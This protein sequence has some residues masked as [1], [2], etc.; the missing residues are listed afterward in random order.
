M[1]ESL[2]QRLPEKL[3]YWNSSDS[4]DI[5]N[6][7]VKQFKSLSVIVIVSLAIYANSIKN[8]F[9]YDD[10]VTIV[11]NT[12]I[13]D[14]HNLPKLFQKEYFELSGEMSY[15]PVVTLT[16]FLDYSLY[17]E[18]P[19]GYHL[20]NIL[21]HALNGT[22]LYVF[23]SLLAKRSAEP[24]I[25]YKQRNLPLIASL[26]FV[27]HPV[28]TEAVNAVSF[29]EDL[30][31]FF[32][33]MITLSLYIILSNCTLSRGRIIVYAFSCLTYFL[34]LFSKEMGATLPLVIFGV[35][36]IY[37]NN[38]ER[39]FIP[40]S[41][42][43]IGY[44]IVTLIYVYLRFYYF[45]NPDEKFRP[46]EVNERILTFPWLF[47]CYLK[48]AFFPFSLVVDY[49]ITPIKS[50]FSPRF[51][52]SSFALISL[53][54]TAFKIKKRE[55]EI[56]FGIVFFMVTLSPVYNLI[57]ISNPFAERYLYLPLLGFIVIAVL[58]I[59]VL[60]KMRCHDRFY[61]MPML[62]FVILSIY[63]ISVVRRN[64]VW[65]DSYSLWSDALKKVPENGRIRN[66]LGSGYSKVGEFEK[67]IENFK[68]SIKLMA[69]N[70]YESKQPYYNLGS[71]Y[72]KLGRLLE[73]IP[74]LEK[75]VE[76]NP[77]NSRWHNE[78]GFT[79]YKAGM[80]NGAIRHFQAALKINPDYF[81]AYNNLGIAYADN[82]MLEEAMQEFRYASRLKPSEPE[83]WNNIG[84]IYFKQARFDEAIQQYQA[85]LKID[86]GYVIAHYNLGNAYLAKGFTD[87]ARAEFEIALK[88][89]P[90]FLQA[91]EAIGSMGK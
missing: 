85:S 79:Y 77:N 22:L 45:Q 63:S 73:A 80:L 35:E 26:L 40:V 33:F 30:L 70:E 18:S 64:E 78:T 42:Y 56:A 29:R 82:G 91:Q 1:V 72:V 54:M 36:W 75:A 50:F 24:E 27:T 76:L 5:L 58:L 23:L 31:V 19:W 71:A 41:R 8:G 81:D 55:K 21:L 9:V 46:W 38:G 49:E 14:I 43:N 89:Q 60:F 62:I 4:S 65:K 34:A 28:L 47:L 10:D 53:L 6:S 16:Y 15:R 67:A 86:P 20:T 11:K 66:N 7:I 61:L 88:L 59:N 87:K 12:L 57:P 69:K 48:I 13:K 52:V 83:I 51:V 37:R 25:S 3:F 84:L 44:I 68:A 90:D 74:Y 17:K 39:R 2:Q 32:F